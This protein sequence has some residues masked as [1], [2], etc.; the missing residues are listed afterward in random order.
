MALSIAIAI[1][2]GGAVYQW[3]EPRNNFIGVIEHTADSASSLKRSK[4]TLLLIAVSM[5]INLDLKGP[6]EVI[7]SVSFLDA[8]LC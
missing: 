8:L 7:Y 1:L 5:K 6:R 4:S 3:R 2:V